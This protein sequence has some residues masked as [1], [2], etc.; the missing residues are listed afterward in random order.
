MRRASYREAI[1]WIADN[2]DTEW[3]TDAEEAS[4]DDGEYTL[5]NTVPS[6]TLCLVMDLF[7]VELHKA[8]TDLKKALDKRTM[9]AKPCRC[10]KHKAGDCIACLNN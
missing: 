8:V 10:G 5:D 3:L 4:W 2:D 7:D 1:Q 6:V 9:Q